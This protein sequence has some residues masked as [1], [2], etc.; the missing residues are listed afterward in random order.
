M[1]LYPDAE[2]LRRKIDIPATIQWRGA[3]EKKMLCLDKLPVVIVD[4]VKKF[5]HKK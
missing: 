3:D 1:S 4:G 2:S 5:T